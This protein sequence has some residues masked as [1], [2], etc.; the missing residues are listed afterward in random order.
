[1]VYHCRI[2]IIAELAPFLKVSI[3]AQL[4]IT[5]DDHVMVYKLLCLC[6]RIQLVSSL[7][8]YEYWNRTSLIKIYSAFDAFSAFDALHSPWVL[9]T[10]HHGPS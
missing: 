2:Y 7:N 1:M 6:L 9:G 8:V 5:T 4:M 3:V 10:M